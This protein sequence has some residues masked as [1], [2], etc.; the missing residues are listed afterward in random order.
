MKNEPLFPT[1]GGFRK[2]NTFQLTNAALVL[3]GITRAL[4]KRQLATLA[5]DF[6]NSGGFSERLHRVRSD[7]RRNA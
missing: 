4:L 6:E 1:H 5:S 3:I 2:L 7:R